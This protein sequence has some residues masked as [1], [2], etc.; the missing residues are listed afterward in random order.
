MSVQAGIV[1]F[2]GAPVERATVH[3]ITQGIVNY[4]PDGEGTFGEGPLRLFYRPLY[5]TAE[6][7]LESQPHVADN[8]HVLMFDGRLDNRDELLHSLQDYTLDCQGDVCVV[9][10]AF[11]RWGTGAFAKLIGDW[12]VTIWIPDKK[13]IILARDYIG[14]KQLFYYCTRRRVLW[15]TSLAALAFCGD[16][17][18]ICDEYI[19]GYFSFWPDAHLTPYREIRSVGPG[20]F[21]SIHDGHITESSYWTFNA[22]RKL[23]YGS[24]AEYEEHFR[25]LFRQAVRRRLRTDGPILAE[26]SGGLDS[27]SVVCM[28]DDILQNEGMQTAAIDTLSF[29]DRSEPDETDLDY[30]VQVEQQRGRVGHHIELKGVGD[31][32][33]FDPSS[34]TATPGFTVR[35]ELKTAQ[36]DVIKRGEYRVV[37]SGSG[38]DQVM[39]RGLDPRIQMAQFVRELRVA[40]LA[41]LLSAWS[42]CSQRPL[43]HLLYQSLAI[44]LPTSLRALM[45]PV[46]EV[47]PWLNRGFALRHEVANRL[48]PAADGAWVWAPIK[49][50]WFQMVCNIGGE[51]TYRGASAWETRYP[52]LDQHLLEFMISIPPDQLV[53]P[54]QRRSLTRRSLVGIVPSAI[55]SRDSKSSCSRCD[56]MTLDKHWSKVEGLL[57][58]PVSA[59]LGYLDP[60]GL[61]RAAEAMKC[62]KVPPYSVGLLRAI[63]L[64]LWLQ[65]A[66]DR[67]LVT[68]PE[69]HQMG[70]NVGGLETVDSA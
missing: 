41:R 4:G 18:T 57:K 10:S 40:D 17:F 24:D 38:G 65:Q 16:R 45:K 13:E 44:L 20:E 42:M 39:G 67:G 36:A 15:C 32:Y 59:T 33:S 14:V 2:D 47:A 29:S 9:S 69:P 60:S 27:S 28:A 37:L 63:S 55:L 3:Q 64:E 12:A 6:A 23:R 7:R 54:G 25:F 46:G 5:T 26:L 52:F 49:R 56:V 62:G 61:R 50:Y 8:G 48:L 30:F 53:R 19:A 34:F 22:D 35:E 21:V 70:L 31:S 51:M 66:A 11:S 58:S 43:C 1:N 68:I